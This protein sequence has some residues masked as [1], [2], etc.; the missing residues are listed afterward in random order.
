MEHNDKNGRAFF[1]RAKPYE[2]QTPAAPGR[3][4]VPDRYISATA[5]AHVGLLKRRI[6]AGIPGHH[7]LRCGD[8]TGPARSHGLAVF[9]MMLFKVEGLSS[10]HMRMIEDPL[11]LALMFI[12]A[13]AA[14]CV[15]NWLASGPQV[16]GFCFDERQQRLTFTQ[17]PPCPANHRRMRCRTAISTPSVPRND[18]FRQLLSLCGVLRRGQWQAD[19]TSVFGCNGAG[20]G[21][22]G[23]VVEAVDWREDA[24]SIGSGFVS[25]TGIA[26]CPQVM[27]LACANK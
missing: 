22:P 5:P 18:R 26:R 17:R 12:S 13:F 6:Q 23:R 8:V 21:A 27:N 7:D 14:V 24:G 20:H 2:T 3:I 16:P 15:I 25:M 19:R 4:P 11:I 1:P 10:I 9:T